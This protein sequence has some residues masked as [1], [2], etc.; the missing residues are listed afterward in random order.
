VVLTVLGAVLALALAT[1]GTAAASTD[2]YHYR[3][4]GPS[5]YGHT[6][7]MTDLGTLGGT[8]SSASAIN[9]LG[10]VTGV[11]DTAG[12]ASH[13]FRWTAAGG[14]RDL[15]TLGGTFSYASAINAPGQV[16]GSADTAGGAPH[17]FRWTP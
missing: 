16:T 14:M 7:T 4:S 9:E 5:A 8:F 13:A 12:G 1:P 11:A 15:G 10:Q 17:A 2:I 6:A 3:V